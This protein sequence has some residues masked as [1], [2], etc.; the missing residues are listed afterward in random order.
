VNFIAA[1][2]EAC[3]PVIQ[4][5]V[6]TQGAPVYSKSGMNR[7]PIQNSMGSKNRWQL[8]T[9]TR[10]GRK[11][12]ISKVT[13]LS[14]LLFLMLSG[15]SAA[16]QQA[17]Q[18]VPD[19][20]AEKLAGI[21]AVVEDAI[22]RKE[23]PGAV[24]LI[25]HRGKV[26]YRKA[27]GH[28]ALVPRE[29]PMTPDTIFDLASLTKVI[30]TTTAVMRLFEQG[31]IR[32]D[33][34][35]TAYWPEF[36]ANGKEH[37]TIRELMTHYSGLPPDLD[38]KPS[39]SGYETAMRMIVGERPIV[40]PGTRFIYSDINF[41]TLGELVRRVSGEPLNA[42]CAAHVFRPLGMKDTF[43][44]PLVTHPGLGNRIA[45]TQHEFG[46]T[47]KI[48]WGEV[49]DPTSYR[50]GGLAGHAG[51]FSTADDLAIF[52]Q[53]L[54]NGGSYEG[55]RILSPLTVEKMTTPQSPPNQMAL[56]GLGWDIGS[57]F[58]SN[59]G[60]LLPVGSFGHTGFTGTS[61]WIDPVTETY[62][63]ILANRVHPDGKGDVVP[64]RVKIANLVAASL[65][66]TSD[67]QILESRKSLTGYE[68]L[69]RGY[70]VMGLRNGKVETG[71]DVLEA[72]HFAP[73]KGLRIGL[74]TNETG[75]DAQGRRTVDVLHDAPGVKLVALFSPEH[76]LYGKADTKVA[77]GTDPETGLPVYS[78]YGDTERPSDQML[79]GIDALVFDIQDVGVR[80]YTFITTLGY[81]MEAAAKKGIAVYVLDRPNPLDGLAVE[82]PMLD[83]DL[84]SFVGYFPLPVR[85]GMTVGEV[86]QLFNG[87][88]KLGAELH[89]VKMRGWERSDWYDETGLE[90]INPSPNLRS[91]TE[92]TLYPGVA[93]VEG[94]NV[95]VGRGT[96]T[97]F[98][99]LGAPWIVSRDLAEYLNERR[100]QGVRFLPTDFQPTSNRYQGKVCHGVQIMLL[101]RQALNSPELGVEIASALQHL[102]PAQ[103]KLDETLPLIG[104]R[105]VVEAIRAGQDPRAIAYAWQDALEAF[106]R[107]RAKYLLY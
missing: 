73:L 25:G 28:R 95:S 87:E 91:L 88:Q 103:F 29:L 107:E 3:F 23:T 53:M 6:D 20:S 52:A 35:V 62:I 33:D 22:R 64:L 12:R 9:G 61:L 27:F 76:G 4:P 85:H 66:Q 105:G 63:I 92:A 2:I 49:H 7:S 68:E 71:M 89:V 100:I 8:N 96:D 17:S 99:L 86:A 74:I 16:A 11:F 21:P 102:Y 90:W 104:S 38:L 69:M 30:A 32:L 10:M 80:F 1:L 24:V 57:P 58:A 55:V 78:L 18:A 41:E 84:K 36:G 15:R 67:Q 19:I 34:P 40:P 43:F 98:E 75:R 5:F 82:G 101:D 42:Y 93:M 37:I 48:L 94:S 47:G 77:S 70:R 60:E 14:G 39:W 79:A 59:R 31:K 51:L 45:P 97:P 81:A 26:V 46:T 44:R 72:D 56:R 54:L 50:M 106:R 83:P 13:L 65:G